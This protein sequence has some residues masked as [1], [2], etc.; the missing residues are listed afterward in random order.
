MEIIEQHIKPLSL[1]ERVAAAVVGPVLGLLP[2]RKQLQITRQNNDAARIMSTSSRI[3]NG[4]ITLYTL[5]SLV[6]NAMGIDINPTQGDTVTNVGIIV[7]IDTVLREVL[8]AGMRAFSI[9]QNHPDPGMSYTEVWGE[10]L[11]S[12]LYAG[13][14]AEKD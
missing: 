14:V 3:T 10:P 4:V 5:A 7:G 12:I 2:P 11:I 13:F 9:H 8:Y 6:G 1:V